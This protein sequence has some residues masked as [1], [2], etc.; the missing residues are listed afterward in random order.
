MTGVQ[1]IPN[2]F[3]LLSGLNDYITLI[4]FPLP[5][6][7]SLLFL[8]F[9]ASN[10]EIPLIPNGNWTSFLWFYSSPSLFGFFPWKHKQTIREETHRHTN[11]WQP[12][13]WTVSARNIQ[14]YAR[15]KHVNLFSPTRMGLCCHS[16]N[17]SSI[18][19]KLY[20]S[21]CLYWGEFKSKSLLRDAS[22]C[23]LHSVDSSNS[24]Y[25]HTHKHTSLFFSIY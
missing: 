24:L 7:L 4:M 19:G 15:G 25:K 5:V 10:K 13:W 21:S 20:S 3:K 1:Y 6:L 18:W 14:L 17:W 9:L 2:N 22:K 16:K 12:K 11:A 23:F 8:K